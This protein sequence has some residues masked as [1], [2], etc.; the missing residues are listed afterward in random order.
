ME[1]STEERLPMEEA[2]AEGSLAS[3]AASRRT[4]VFSVLDL[5]DAAPG[6]PAA[7]EEA[8]TLQSAWSS[9]PMEASIEERLPMEEVPPGHRSYG[10]ATFSS[11]P[12]LSWC[13]SSS[14]ANFASQS[15]TADWTSVIWPT[16]CGLSTLMC[17]FSRLTDVLGEFT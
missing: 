15:S 8:E 10:T 17:I 14:F 16:S 13:S 9:S 1:A 5:A 11:S 2:L 6:P 3:E 4:S 7:V 12:I